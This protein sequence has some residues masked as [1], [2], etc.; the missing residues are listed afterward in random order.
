ML[1]WLFDEVSH[2]DLAI[3]QGHLAVLRMDNTSKNSI[4]TAEAVSKVLLFSAFRAQGT[5]SFPRKGWQKYIF[6]HNYQATVEIF[7]A[8]ASQLTCQPLPDR[9]TSK[10]VSVKRA[11]NVEGTSSPPNIP[12]TFFSAPPH[13]VLSANGITL[14]FRSL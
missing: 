2:V 5:R 12:V 13:G 6:L 9:G 1:I 3:R 4:G 11:A 14:P 7:S 10:N 8:F